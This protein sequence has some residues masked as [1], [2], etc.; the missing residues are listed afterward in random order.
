[1][2]FGFILKKVISTL[3]TPLALGMM[4]MLLALFFVRK[5]KMRKA[6]MAITA[7][8]LWFFLL[9]YA[10]VGN[11]LLHKFESAYPPLL[12]APTD[13]QYIY[14]LGHGHSSDSKLPITSQLYDDAVIRLNEA[15]R[16]YQQLGEKAKIIV[17][18]YSGFYSDIP[19]AVMQQ[20]L[21]IALG[22]DPKKIILLPNPRDTQE[23][24][25]AAKKLLKNEPFV[26]ITS[27][28]HMERA[29]LWFKQEGLSPVP[30]PT[31]HQT[32]TDQVAYY[33]F[34][35]AYALK[36]STIAFHEALGVLWQKIK[37]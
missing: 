24:A 23:E 6:S 5:D 31:R 28:F 18:G 14:V 32:G 16:L 33:G 21:A 37:G 11:H 4:L 9:S 13:I 25:K 1:M 7:A 36:L 15:I 30:A 12:Q 26:L 19:H 34:F 3:L 8:F 35:S 22:V 2:G 27:A 20:K 17:S 29:M 10:P